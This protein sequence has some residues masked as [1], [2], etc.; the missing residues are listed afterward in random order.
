MYFRKV[1]EFVLLFP[2]LLLLGL[3]ENENTSLDVGTLGFP[4]CAWKA[5]RRP[6]ERSDCVLVP[7][8]TSG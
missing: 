4:E 7:N 6:G 1:D 5:G 3:L 2:K 8:V